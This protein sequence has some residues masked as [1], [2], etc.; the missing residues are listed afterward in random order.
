MRKRLFGL[1]FALAFVGLLS[2]VGATYAN[3]MFADDGT[4]V[5]IAVM[6]AQ[7]NIGAAFLVAIFDENNPMSSL[8]AAA[9]DNTARA[10]ATNFDN[11]CKK[12]YTGATYAIDRHGIVS[13]QAKLLLASATFH[14]RNNASANTTADKS[15]LKGVTALRATT[16]TAATAQLDTA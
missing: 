13:R 5:A 3:V 14:L 12:G 9:L 16:W 8:T 11:F 15:A 10:T 1:V 6:P 2:L 4:V 7:P